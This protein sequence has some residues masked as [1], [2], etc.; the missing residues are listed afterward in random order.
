MLLISLIYFINRRLG[1]GDISKLID[2]TGKKFGRLTV[3]RRA[4]DKIQ[5][6]GRHRVMWE[7]MCECGKRTIVN[8]DNLKRGTTQS[9]GCYADELVK[10]AKK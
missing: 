1:D 6:N 5:D 9:C 7:C 3:V 10:E 4:Q 8:G 2:L